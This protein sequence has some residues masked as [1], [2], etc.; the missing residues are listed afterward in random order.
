M[1]NKEE[2][3]QIKVEL[4]DDVATGI[5]TNLASLSRSGNDIIIDFARI[6][7]GRAVARVE[8]RVIMSPEHAK[9]LAALLQRNLEE[10]EK[11]FGKIPAVEDVEATRP[12]GFVPPREEK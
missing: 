9:R 8:S 1:E 4:P 12:M 11:R 7:P 2:I 3:A 5:Y 10:Y 6:V